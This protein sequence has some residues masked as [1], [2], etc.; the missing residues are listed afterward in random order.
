MPGAGDNVFRTPEDRFA[1]LPAEFASWEPQYLDWS[2]IR[3]ARIDEGEGKPVV[4]FHGEP[5]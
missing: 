5:T 1:D 3:L 4:L 2:G